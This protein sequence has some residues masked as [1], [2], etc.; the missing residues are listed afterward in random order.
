[1]LWEARTTL[2]AKT[3]E[4]EVEVDGEVGAS[5]ARGEDGCFGFGPH[6]AETRPQAVVPIAGPIQAAVGTVATLDVVECD[7]S[8][9]KRSESFVPPGEPTSRRRR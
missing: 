1:M 6:E 2:P 8:G 7:L 4:I 5:G 3:I 9:D